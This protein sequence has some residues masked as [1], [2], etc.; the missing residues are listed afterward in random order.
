M[1]RPFLILIL[2]VLPLF[3]GTNYP[4]YEKLQKSFI[5]WVQINTKNNIINHQNLAISQ[6]MKKHK[7]LHLLCNIKL[8]KKNL[9]S[10]QNSKNI[11][12]SQNAFYKLMLNKKDEIFDC[13]NFDDIRVSDTLKSN[14][15]NTS[16]NTSLNMLP[17]NFSVELEDEIMLIYGKD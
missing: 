9:Q 15:F 11:L 10:L 12:D 14:S 17:L 7:N 16:S 5:F 2:L 4:N 13:L 6:S 3:G 8:E 1:E